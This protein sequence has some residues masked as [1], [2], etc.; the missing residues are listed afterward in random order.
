[1]DGLLNA[2]EARA[3]GALIE[4]EI[5]VPE[6]YPLTLNALVAAC[7][8]KNNRNPVMVLYEAD[9]TRALES[10]REK[11]LAWVVSSA[12]A[13]VPKYSH[14]LKGRYALSPQQ[15]AI[16]CELMLRGPQTPGELRTHGERLGGAATM[17]ELE[18]VLQTLVNFP[19]GPLVTKLPRE[20]GFRE[21][22]YAHLLCGP[23]E[24]Q[25]AGAPLPPPPAAE[26]TP[27][28]NDRI[29]ALETE[30]RNLR[31]A[32]EDMRLQLAEFRKQFE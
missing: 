22:R 17:S 3:L 29:L 10:L 30:V 14:N 4:K 15:T 24:I 32:V 12:G 2:I 8:Q 16:L 19:A 26:Q 25:Q 9:I 11:Q 28:G 1:M 6:T 5:T 20:T 23:V 7:D 13:R 18:A 21:C 31:Q 27:A